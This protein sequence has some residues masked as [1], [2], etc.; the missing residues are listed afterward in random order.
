MST[1]EVPEEHLSSFLETAMREVAMSGDDLE[2]AHE[3][4]EELDQAI[5]KVEAA[6]AAYKDVRAG[7]PLSAESVR[8]L[9]QREIDWECGDDGMRLPSSAEE[10]SAFAARFERQAFLIDLRDRCGVA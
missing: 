2:H 10:C 6:V 5:A 9:A 3:K 7:L 4:P 8:F 1:I